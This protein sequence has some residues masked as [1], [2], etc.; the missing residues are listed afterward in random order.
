[1]LT[2]PA[3]EC[4]RLTDRDG[5]ALR[6][7][8]AGLSDRSR[9]LRFHTGVSRYPDSWW[10]R[11]GRVEPGVCDA[12]LARVDGIPVG[13]G[14]W[15]VV[16]EATAD[17]ALAVV[18]TWH[19]RGVATALLDHLAATARDAGVERFACWVHPEN[20]PVR[21]MLLSRDARHDAVTGAWVLDLAAGCAHVPSSQEAAA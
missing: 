3:P 11:L 5:D 15:H 13:H 4:L 12:A 1:M 9:F 6:A 21:E 20:S 18:D 14:Q 16:S 7:V 17:V 10:D 19:R 8:F 2:H